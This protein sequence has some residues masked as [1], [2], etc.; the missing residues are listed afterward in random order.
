MK[1]SALNRRQQAR[2]SAF[3][4]LEERQLLAVT[5]T[6]FVPQTADAEASE[7]A[8]VGAL[9]SDAAV[10]TIVVDTIS[11]AIDD[12]DGYTSLPEAIVAAND[13][14]TIV[15][16]RNLAETTITLSSELTIDKSITIDGDNRIVLDGDKTSRIFNVDGTTGSHSLTLLNISLTQGQAEKGGAVCV[17]SG[18]ALT[19]ENVKAYGNA[20]VGD[21]GVICN[22]GGE[23]TITSGEFT[24]N[25]GG[26]GGVICNNAGSVNV[27]NADFSG[28]MARS[29]G[30]VIYNAAFCE[31]TATNSVFTGNSSSNTG[32]AIF[33][34]GNLTL[35]NDVFSGNSATTGGGVTHRGS[36][37]AF[38]AT[39]CVFSGNTANNNGGAIYSTA[40]F[41]LCNTTIAGNKALLGGGVWA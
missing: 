23:V 7:S 2:K 13:G 20:A 27:T 26:Y 36:M 9:A 28:N 29:Q 18:C 17:G 11:A 3:E 32:G 21:G 24:G 16:D 38:S 35:T 25:S 4:P 5:G 10:E 33:N 6:A 41:S 31:L 37:G 12:A 22:D 8:L 14:A 15:F 1:K 40:S 30:G 19:L 39:N 34:N